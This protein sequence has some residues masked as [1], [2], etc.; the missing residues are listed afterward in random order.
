[1]TDNESPASGGTPR[2]SVIIPV[3]D[4]QAGLDDCL[5]ALARQTHPAGRTQIIVVDDGSDPPMKPRS[6]VAAHVL[7]V[8][9]RGSYAA[10]NAGAAQ[11]DGDILAFTDSDTI[12]SPG[13]LAA[14]ARALLAA[15]G[16]VIAGAV[17][18]TIGDRPSG[19]E[20]FDQRHG[21]PQEF[22][23]RH[24]NAGATAN[25]FVRRAEWDVVGPFDAT[26][27]SGGDMEWGW[28]AAQAGIP[29]HFSP[30]VVVAHP[31][32]RSLRELWR[33]NRRILAGRAELRRRGVRRDGDRLS[34]LLRPQLRH[35]WRSRRELRGT[36]TPLPWLRYVGAH[37]ANQVM[38]LLLALRHHQFEFAGGR[39]R[40]WSSVRR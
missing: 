5:D 32:R 31:A 39:L 30:D 8:D 12:P 18:V 34:Q 9:H 26:L 7:R 27:Q 11:A 6:G 22:Y 3:R 28:R 24:R 25:L 16:T 33:K 13:W 19:V 10:R 2:I 14:G 29:V 15:P 35:Y 1:M 23:A 37:V 20:I 4:N 40:T 21:F 38:T 36:A 17:N